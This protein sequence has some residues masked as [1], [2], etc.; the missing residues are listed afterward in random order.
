M[1]LSS[2][3]RF[4]VLPDIPMIESG[5]DLADILLAALARAPVV[6]G[7]GD[8]LVVAQ[9]IV[10]KA[11]GR[12]VRLD[13]VTASPR[14]VELAGETDKD[15]RLVQLILDESTEILRT[16][17]GVLIVRHRLGNVGAHAGIDQS[18][19]DHGDGECALL[20]PVDPDRSAAQLR[21]TILARTGRVV[22]VIIADSMNRAWRLG[23]IGGA[24]GCA[25]ITVLDDLRGTNDLYGRELKV[26]VI[27]RADSLA[28]TAC[29][30][31]GESIQRTP[32]VLVQ[33]L[34]AEDATQT[35]RDLIRPLAEDMFR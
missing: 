16:R 29:L 2:Q 19:V 21:A 4:Q 35:A 3:L 14:A 26:T 6:L 8:V 12:L 25:G 1:S 9:K 31:M 7:D 15:P 30:L 5:N 24:I 17:P 22:G 13:T 27:N 33:G 32:A 28:A 18:N 20:L 11:E 34:P 23:T 10:S